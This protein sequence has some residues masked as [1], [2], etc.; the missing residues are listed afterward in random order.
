MPERRSR[1]V[2]QHVEFEDLGVE[3][4]EAIEIGGHDRDVIDAG[5]EFHRAPSHFCGSTARAL[6]DQL[7]GEG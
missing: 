7:D 1:L 6:D 3:R 2:E 5:D 4:D